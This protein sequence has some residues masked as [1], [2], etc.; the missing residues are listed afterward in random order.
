MKVTVNN[1]SYSIDLIQSANPAEDAV[2]A[3]AAIIEEDLPQRLANAELMLDYGSV[4]RPADTL[5]AWHRVMQEPCNAR[6]IDA[7][8]SALGLMKRAEPIQRGRVASAIANFTGA[9]L[10]AEL[11]REI[12]L[13]ELERTLADATEA[14]EQVRAHIGKVDS[15]RQENKADRISLAAHKKAGSDPSGAHCA[16]TG[17]RPPDENHARLRRKVQ[18]LANILASAEILQLELARARSTAIDLLERQTTL[19]NALVPIWRQ[20][21]G[22]ATA[23]VAARFKVENGL[24]QTAA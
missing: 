22:R 20:H 23:T 2:H 5:D 7:L 14:A 12:A 24:A 17:W 11:K 3:L 15:L 21:G 8:H 10:E 6:L 4:R 19:Q 13:C 18:E 16:G 9:K 1:D